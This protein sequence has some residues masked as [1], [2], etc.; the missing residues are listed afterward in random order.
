MA[1]GDHCPLPTACRIDIRHV[2]QFKS[3]L[4]PRA[5][6]NLLLS[7][8]LGHTC[9]LELAR[10]FTYTLHVAPLAM[11]AR[12][13]Y[14]WPLKD[15]SCPSSIFAPSWQGWVGHLLHAGERPG[16]PR[17][18]LSFVY[19]TWSAIKT[20]VHVKIVPA[21]E[22]YTVAEMLVRHS[23]LIRPS[24]TYVRVT[25]CLRPTYEV[26]VAKNPLECPTRAVGWCGHAA[27]AAHPLASVRHRSWRVTGWNSC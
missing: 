3:H 16:S 26:P 5:R 4:V 22:V 18:P 10:G 13:L 1:S 20:H 25:R 21:V 19:S 6:S 14:L 23:I 17:C 27:Y 7:A 15:H 9:Y 12:V 2:H 24:S 11:G 8:S